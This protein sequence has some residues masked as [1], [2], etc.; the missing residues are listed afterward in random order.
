MLKVKSVTTVPGRRPKKVKEVKDHVLRKTAVVTA[1][2][3]PEMAKA[4]DVSPCLAHVQ[5]IFKN[6]E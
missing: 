1:Y 6:I 4:K 2:L 5:T 3:T